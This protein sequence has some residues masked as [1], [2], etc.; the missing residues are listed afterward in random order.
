MAHIVIRHI[1]GTRRRRFLAGF[2]AVIVIVALFGQGWVAREF[3]RRLARGLA[4]RGLVLEHEGRDWNPWRGLRLEQLTI[5]HADSGLPVAESGN[6]MVHVPLGRW[7]RGDT[8]TL[9][10]QIRDAAMTL[11]DL[12]GSVDF[13]RVLLELDTSSGEI[14][15]RSA[16]IANAGLSVSLHG[17]IQTKTPAGAKAPL[18]FDWDPVRKVLAA[19][20]IS[21]SGDPFQITGDFR[22]DTTSGK[23]LWSTRL[24]GEGRDLAW[25]GIALPSAEA[26]AVLSSGHSKLT[27]AMALPHGSAVLTF[28]REAWSAPFQFRGELVDGGRRTTSFRGSWQ[29]QQLEIDRLEGTAN[30]W[31]IAKGIPAIEPHLPRHLTVDTFPGYEVDGIRR[32]GRGDDAMWSVGNILL[33]KAGE[34]T[35]KVKDR[36]LRVTH[37]TGQAGFDGS[38]WQFEQCRGKLFGGSVVVDGSLADGHLR[39]SRFVVDGIRWKDL[40][41]W[42]GHKG[43]RASRGILHLDYN[44]DLDLRNAQA[45]GAGRVRLENAPVFEVPLLDETYDLFAAMIPGVKPG[46]EGQFDAKF[47]ARPGMLEVTRFEAKGGSLTVSAAGTVDLEKQR[48]DGRARGK[49]SGLPGLVTSPLGRLLEMD[50][51]GP[52]DDIQVKPLGPAKLVSNAASTALDAPVEVL[53]EAGRIAGTVVLEGIKLP[54]RLFSKEKQETDGAQE[55]K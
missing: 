40:R 54:F 19:L 4:E 5:R 53:E 46:G 25:Q 7:L 26:S 11:H 12:H 43:D 37:L 38:R 21:K 41:Q 17:T 2:A 44:G 35:A 1:L 28:E 29:G 9:H 6:L 33:T 48:I 8:K 14:R 30:L 32:E 24:R 22:V 34:L 10:W 18:T 27:A 36:D 45:R 52:Y 47:T 23:P 49:L 13:E 42:A 31:D 50:V 3:E 16:G 55:K 39:K 51:A 15:V 20:D